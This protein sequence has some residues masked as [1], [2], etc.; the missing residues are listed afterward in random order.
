M[1]PYQYSTEATAYLLRNYAYDPQTGAVSNRRTGRQLKPGWKHGGYLKYGFRRNGH[2]VN[3]SAHRLAWLLHY[4]QWPA[5]VIDHIDGNPANN[6][7]TNLRCCSPKEN[8]QNAYYPWSL[9]RDTGLPGVVAKRKQPQTFEIFMYHCSI[10]GTDPYR[11][12]ILAAL[13]GRRYQLPNTHHL[14]P[15]THDTK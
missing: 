1:K 13:L 5:D 14:T 10:S 7:I 15:I 9:N 4:G 2:Y 6:C 12:F 11:L 8:K 3:I